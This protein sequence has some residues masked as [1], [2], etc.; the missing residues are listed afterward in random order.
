VRPPLL[1]FHGW[2]GSNGNLREWLPALEPRFQVIAPDLPGCAGVAPLA[3]RHTAAAYAR[4]ALALLDDRGIDTALVGGL[5]SGSSIALALARLWPERVR[6]LLLHTPFARPA[7]IRPLVRL[8]LRLLTSPAGALYAPLRNSA[9]LAMLHRRLFANGAMV[10]AEN[11]ARDQ[12]DL[13]RADPRAA[14]ELAADLLLADQVAVLRDWRK[15]LFAL[16]ASEDAF[17]D[18][19]R[20]ASLIREVTPQASVVTFPGGHGWTA[21][22]IRRQHEALLGIA[23]RLAAALDAR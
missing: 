15:P 14:R 12:A 22:Y 21:D 6:G 5:C 10:A 13:V 8:Q 11:L 20:C 2:S 17:I 4:W 23:A 19:Q 16:F 9:T 3:E 7:L 18:T 1:L